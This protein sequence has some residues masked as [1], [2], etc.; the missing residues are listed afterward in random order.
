M[1]EGVNDVI[2]YYIDW[3]LID[4]TLFEYLLLFTHEQNWF[5]SQNNILLIDYIVFSIFTLFLICIKKRNYKSQ[6]SKIPSRVA[7]VDT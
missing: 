3:Y 5:S 6:D 4:T 7:I 2:N 1:S